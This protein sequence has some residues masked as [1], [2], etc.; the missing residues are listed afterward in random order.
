MADVSIGVQRTTLPTSSTT[1]HDVTVSGIGT[2]SAAIFIFYRDTG[3]AGNANQQ[4]CVMGYGFTDGSNHFSS[5]ADWDDNAS[6]HDGARA[7]STS[8]VAMLDHYGSNNVAFGSWITDGVRL[9][10]TNTS[11]LTGCHVD[12]ILFAGDDVDAAVGY[13]Q[14]PGSTGSTRTISSLSFQ[15]KLIFA[16]TSGIANATNQSQ[17]VISWGVAHDTGSGIEQSV[18]GRGAA[19]NTRNLA[20]VRRNDGIATQPFTQSTAW[21][22]EVTSFTSDGFV[23]TERDNNAGSDDVGYLCLALGDAGIKLNDAYGT[24]TATGTDTVGTTTF[25]PQFFM[26]SI[27]RD[28][29]SSHDTSSTNTNAGEV[30]SNTLIDELQ[31]LFNQTQVDRANSSTTVT[32][33]YR[34]SSTTEALNLFTDKTVNNS[35]DEDTL[36]VADFDSFSA[37]GTVLDYTTVSGGGSSQRYYGWTLQIEEGDSAPSATIT[38]TAAAASS[39]VSASVTSRQSF[40]PRNRATAARYR[41]YYLRSE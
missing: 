33:A 37:T 38:T 4:D 20:G 19:N 7:Q 2:P 6:S 13:F 34:S 11:G 12:L 29:N 21:R 5:Y 16:T 22:Q 26:S 14:V 8:Y 15:P 23:V 27:S 9:N 30:I 40:K 3:T 32:A 24:P 1:T 36:A 28:T 39:S 25:T 10:V 18:L 31:S 17:S 35:F 41:G